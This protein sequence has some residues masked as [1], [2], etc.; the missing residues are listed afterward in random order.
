MRYQKG[1]TLI[2]VM[3]STVI[4]SICAVSIYQ[5]FIAC[6]EGRIAAENYNRATLLMTDEIFKFKY[7]R[8]DDNASRSFLDEQKHRSFEWDYEISELPD[9]ERITPSYKK[10]T[11]TMKWTGPGEHRKGQMVWIVGI[12]MSETPH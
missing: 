1:F 5:A 9:T 11:F 7:G 8:L 6:L 4:V 2:E 12:N 10:L 3:I